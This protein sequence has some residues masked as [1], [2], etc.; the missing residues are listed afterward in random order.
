MTP[1][2]PS[3]V[4]E[5]VNVNCKE[6][7]LASPFERGRAEPHSVAAIHFQTQYFAAAGLDHDRCRLVLAL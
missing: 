6:E 2:S 3:T 5:E 1:G 7:R 4:L